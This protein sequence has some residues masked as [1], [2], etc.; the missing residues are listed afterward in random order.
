MC[1]SMTSAVRRGCFQPR[2]SSSP[3]PMPYLRASATLPLWNSRL[4]WSCNCQDIILNLSKKRIYSLPNIL[5]S[6]SIIR[7][8]STRGCLLRLQ[9]YSNTC[10]RFVPLLFDTNTLNNTE[11]VILRKRQTL[12]IRPHLQ[13]HGPKRKK[14]PPRY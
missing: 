4:P 11:K 3:N 6:V 12:E 14:S 7:K 10:F 1:K 13:S 2:G 5:S 9:N 8:E